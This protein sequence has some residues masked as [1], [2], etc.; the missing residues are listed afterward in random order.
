MQNGQH[1]KLHGVR[2]MAKI[3][4]VNGPN[5]N[6]LGTREPE[7]YGNITLE[8]LNNQLKATAEQA[9][10]KAI[11]FQSN[12]EKELIDCIQQAA[13]QKVDYL[14]INPGAYGHTSIAIR[15][16]LLGVQLPFIE[17]HLSNIYARETFRHHSF[18]SDI[19]QGVICG[20]GTQSYQ[21]ALM[22]IIHELKAE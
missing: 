10:H 19:A 9:N 20:L 2:I 18:L 11:F 7:V 6:L 1:P 22:A 12:G 21:A 13:E 15:D 5:L 4:I 14:I 3:L 17:V 16:A 8:Q